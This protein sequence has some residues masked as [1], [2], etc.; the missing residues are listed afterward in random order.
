MTVGGESMQPSARP[1]ILFLKLPATILQTSPSAS[2]TSGPTLSTG[3]PSILD[4]MSAAALPSQRTPSTPHNWPASPTMAVTFLG[5][6]SPAAAGGN[7]HHNIGSK[8]SR[9]PGL[10]SGV[11]PSGPASKGSQ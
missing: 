1:A 8:N 3:R 5:L 9:L 6:S 10:S 7:L 4:V 2:A 11:Q